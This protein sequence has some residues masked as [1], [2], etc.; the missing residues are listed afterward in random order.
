MTSIAQSSDEVI[1]HLSNGEAGQYDI[2]V[3][4]DGVQSSVRQ[5]VFK[6]QRPNNIGWQTWV[7]WVDKR[8]S[9]PGAV[10]EYVEPERFAVI[11]DAGEK[12]LINLMAPQQPQNE[13]NKTAS[14][15]EELQELF[16]DV[17]I[18][19]SEIL[20]TL[21]VADLVHTNQQ[22]IDMP[23]W[24]SNR[25]VLLGDAA[26]GFGPYAGLGGSMAMEDAYV[27]AGELMKSQPDVQ[28]RKTLVEYERKRK[29]RVARARQLTQKMKAFALIE[30]ALLR[31][32]T[33]TILPYFP[34]SYFTKEYH[35]L[36]REEV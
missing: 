35:S 6:D 34:K 23:T 7:A 29:K 12:A 17:E 4:A 32:I 2:V 3:G 13:D 26:H 1:V 5:M 28:I 19:S 22:Y 15:I 27:L 33:N 24:S 11:F 9:T 31:K 25:V 10:M 36:L 14:T 21:T 30:S 16:K 20:P 18:I 8:F